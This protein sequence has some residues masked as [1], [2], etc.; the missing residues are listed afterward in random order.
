MTAWLLGF[1]G[2]VFWHQDWRYNLPTPRPS[3]LQQQREGVFLSLPAPIAAL[4]NSR[5]GRPTLL[6]F[7]NPGCPCSRFNLDHVKAL[8][9]E[10]QAEALFVAVVPGAVGHSSVRAAEERRLGMPVIYDSD[11]AIA[12]TCGVYSTPQAVILDQDGRLRYR[13]NYNL[14]R[15]CVSPATEFARLA[16]EGT[17]AGK[18]S[19]AFPAVA[20]IAYGCALPL[21]EAAR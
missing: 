16:L 15:Y 5:P 14:S 7:F 6:H 2:V 10:H 17:L 9:R 3:G 1:V 19:P 4:R 18:P 21:R 20:T 12:A 8:A 13:G 11:G